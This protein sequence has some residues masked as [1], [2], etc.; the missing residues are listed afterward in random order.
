M[1]TET[2]TLPD[3]LSDLIEVA[4][5]DLEKT[6]VDPRYRVNMNTW[7]TPHKGVCH[8]CLAG[9]V[10]AQTLKLD[11]VVDYVRD[12]SLYA[13]DRKL[14][15]LNNVRL[16]SVQLALDNMGFKDAPHWSRMEVPHY[17][18]DAAGFKTTLR[19]LATELRAKG[20]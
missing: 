5:D 10:M 17:N 18:V 8:V 6:A 13:V 7:H 16:G 15:A 4:L 19:Q 9:A 11:P 1:K 3:K 2:D 14:S 12:R 20:Y